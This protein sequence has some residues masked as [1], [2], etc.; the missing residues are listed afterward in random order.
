MFAN[1]P[2]YEEFELPAI[3]FHCRQFN[4]R[5]FPG[6]VKRIEAFPATECA[7]IKLSCQLRT[8]VGDFH[9]QKSDSMI[10]GLVMIK[11]RITWPDTAH[12]K[13][14]A[15]ILREVQPETGPNQTA[16]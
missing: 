16:A 12:I 14:W 8:L 2:L 9:H 5:S 11:T 13:E 3:C 7:C 10:V 15:E 6:L 4:S 1:Q